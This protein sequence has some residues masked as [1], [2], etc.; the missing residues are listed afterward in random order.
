[1][2][3]TTSSYNVTSPTAALLNPW[4][5][6]IGQQPN[7]QIAFSQQMESN[8]LSTFYIKFYD[9]TGKALSINLSCPAPAYNLCTIFPKNTDGSYLPLT[10]GMKYT[11]YLQT[12]VG[13]S[14]GMSDVN[15]HPLIPD[16]GSSGNNQYRS[17]SFIAHSTASGT[18]PS[19]YVIN[20]NNSGFL[21]PRTTESVQIMFSEPVSNVDNTTV[22]IYR[23]K[24]NSSYPVATESPTLSTTGNV[25]NF[26]L[27]TKLYYSHD[28]CISLSN[29]IVNSSGNSPKQ[30]SLSYNTQI[31]AKAPAIESTLSNSTYVIESN[32]EASVTDSLGNVYMTGSYSTSGAN[33][34]AYYLAKYDINGKLQWQTLAD[35][36][37]NLQFNI[38]KVVV[39]ADQNI[40]LI[41]Y[42][43]MNNNTDNSRIFVR[44]YATNGTTIAW[45]YQDSDKYGNYSGFYQGRGAAILNNSLY[46]TGSKS[47]TE[48]DSIDG[49]V[50]KFALDSE[51]VM[52]KMQFYP[53]NEGKLYANAITYDRINSNLF[54]TGST[55]GTIAQGGATEATVND[56]DYE[57]F[58][59]E[60][61]PD[62]AMVKS[63]QFGTIDDTVDG[64][65]D[66]VVNPQDIVIY[67]KNNC[68][69]KLIVG[70]TNYPIAG[71]SDYSNIR[72]TA[73]DG[74]TTDSF[75]HY[76][77]L[78][79]SGC[80]A[81]FSNEFGMSG[82]NTM[83]RSAVQL[84]S[85]ELYVAGNTT[86]KSW[87]GYSW[88]GSNT[89]ANT[90]IGVMDN[91]LNINDEATWVDNNWV[92]LTSS[93]YQKLYTIS[94]N[95]NGDMY[96]SGVKKSTNNLYPAKYYAYLVNHF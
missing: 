17:F 7:I 1:S 72:V 2:V 63:E 48:A 86:A 67:H 43:Y 56:S 34:N 79:G 73:K 21:S 83:L 74:K 35:S 82:S 95:D 76:I 85:G 42:T 88:T 31:Y 38:N 65:A 75:M 89:I 4:D 94:A 69:Y 41:G 33:N 11:V 32:N 18:Q 70:S 8:T 25:Y 77:P 13:G 14:R 5:N 58:V 96:I 49:F 91:S 59:V 51:T 27:K 52:A 87:A 93:V 29:T 39:D 61:T 78:N 50:Y 54:V 47:G 45:T 64:H 15:N 28:Y 6:V 23:D 92:Y 90:I 12:L 66:S 37:A 10:D 46:V 71:L 44:K 60:A 55:Q 53:Q 9:A 57:G 30:S 36:E 40:Y 20:T 80:V 24:C 26:V 81:A 62:L 68:D 3:F 84:T 19:A 16:S 22:K